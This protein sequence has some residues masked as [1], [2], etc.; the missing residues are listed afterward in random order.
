MTHPR[1]IRAIG[2]LLAV[3]LLSG[4]S[5]IGDDTAPDGEPQQQASAHD[6]SIRSVGRPATHDLL[7]PMDKAPREE[8]TM[9]AADTD[10]RGECGETTCT[11]T[12]RPLGPHTLVAEGNVGSSSREGRHHFRTAIDPATGETVWSNSADVPTGETGSG[13]ICLGGSAGALLCV[14]TG[15]GEY[16]FRTISAKTGEEIDRSPFV[17]APSPETSTLAGM[18]AERRGDVYHA[19]VL[20]HG[21][22][23]D[24]RAASV[25]AVRLAADGSLAWQ[26]QSPASL[27]NPLL[28]ETHLLGDQ[29][30]ITH[31][32]T[33][34]GEPFAL[35]AETGDRV[36]M[37]SDN[38]DALTGIT[39]SAREFVD[40]GS[41]AEHRIV[42]D[43]AARQVLPEGDLD[44]EPLWSIPS[45]LAV[46]AVCGGGVALTDDDGLSLRALDDGSERWEHPLAGSAAV[47][48]DGTHLIVADGNGLTALDAETGEEEWSVDG[49]W[50][51]A[52]RIIA[53]D[54]AG[55]SQRFAVISA[56]ASGE[57]TITVFEAPPLP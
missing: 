33:Q 7:A 48:C 45:D 38:A 23:A 36:T 8:F 14:E 37:S 54:P 15:P 3:G 46:G 16:A 53:L 22:D 18:S 40:D 1:R 55:T 32:T 39:A 49:P 43:G 34:D 42:H 2:A 20:L 4:C 57:E 44:E 11:V 41:A 13:E 51:G 29:L 30:V 24:T 52:R 19:S 21:D 35:S 28:S 25:H 50:E 12:W 26:N 47:S 31:V 27:G 5:L 10:P 17:E 6:Q 56:A 9:P